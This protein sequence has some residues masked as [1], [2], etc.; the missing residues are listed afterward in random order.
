M[1]TEQKLPSVPLWIDG[2]PCAASSA[3][4][5]EITN[6]ATGKVTKTIPFCNAAD[7]DKAVQAATKAL[8]AWRDAPV[9]RRARVLMK[10]RELLEANRTELAQLVT[11]SEEHTSELQSH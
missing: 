7:I 8:P 11:R 6:P 1:S 10:F 9:L 4:A 3:R 2:K 5:G